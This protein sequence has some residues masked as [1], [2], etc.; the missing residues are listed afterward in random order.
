MEFRCQRVKFDLRICSRLEASLT[1]N[2]LASANSLT[3]LLYIQNIIYV[4]I[5]FN[6]IMYIIVPNILYFELVS[7]LCLT[8]LACSFA[9][10]YVYFEF[11]SSFSRTALSTV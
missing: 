1:E 7:R 2:V 9:S 3:R 8:S 6:N 10:M 11:C 4:T 5:I